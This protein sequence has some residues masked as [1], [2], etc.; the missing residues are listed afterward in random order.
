MMIRICKKIHDDFLNINLGICRANDYVG[1]SKLTCNVN[2]WHIL[3]N[4][5]IDTFAENKILIILSEL[6]YISNL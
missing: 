6:H 2:L 1:F 3:C 4:G 5:I